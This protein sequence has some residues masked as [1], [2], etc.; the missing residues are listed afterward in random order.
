MAWSMVFKMI[1]KGAQASGDWMSAEAREAEAKGQ[2]VLM[3]YAADVKDQDAVAKRQKG[4]FDQLQSGRR[5]GEAKGSARAKIGAS[6]VVGSEGAPVEIEA[7]FDYERALQDALI[8]FE[9]ETAARK[10]ESA[11]KGLRTGAE[12]AD[13]RARYTRS[14]KQFG[15]IS[16]LF[17]GAGSMMGGMGK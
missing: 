3:R 6:G 9:S 11:A 2:A 4:Q 15:V 8:G 12:Y 14:A 5:F 16:S 7:A 10:D 13:L 17:G 1:G